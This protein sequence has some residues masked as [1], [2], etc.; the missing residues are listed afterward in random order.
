MLWTA[1]LTPAQD[2]ATAVRSP[3]TLAKYVEAHND[4][5]WDEMAKAL[6]I[7]DDRIYLQEC[8]PCTARLIEVTSPAQAIVV[9]A[10]EGTGL[11]VLLRY[12]RTTRNTWKFTDA[13]SPF[14][15]FDN[16]QSLRHVGRKSF[17]V[18]SGAGSLGTGFEATYEDWFDLIQPAFAP[19]F[20][21]IPKSHILFTS[22]VVG[23]IAT[24]RISGIST[25]PGEKITVE[26]SV[27][28]VTNAD[29]L[30]LFRRKAKGIFVRGAD[31]KF[32]LDLTRST[33]RN[34]E[35]Q[36][37]FEAREDEASWAD[38]FLKFNKAELTGIARGTN[39]EK[40]TWLIAWLK[41][42]PDTPESRDLKRLFSLRR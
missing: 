3:H 36:D 27:D 28:F 20:S 21:F 1:T 37:F 26:Y 6:G 32:A 29:Q 10:N 23:R 30:L 14:A 39:T 12:D 8:H 4:F 24:A 11:R 42:A 5:A 18:N 9:L 40:R 41:T 38:H 22:P 35:L 16:Q 19:V 2:F 31:G 34:A 33:V 13:W 17:L 25:T 7:T 15:K